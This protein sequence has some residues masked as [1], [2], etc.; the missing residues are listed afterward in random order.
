[1]EARRINIQVHSQGDG[2]TYVREVQGASDTPL[3]D[4]RPANPLLALGVLLTANV[5]LLIL[6]TA[7]LG[8][9][10][11]ILFLPIASDDGSSS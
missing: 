5:F 1:V 7:W 8:V 2:V 9:A 10:F 11:V 3:P 4:V 6:T